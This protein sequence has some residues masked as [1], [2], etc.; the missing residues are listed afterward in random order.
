MIDEKRISENLKTFS[1]PRLSG[2][3]FEKKSYR[4]ARQ[5]IEDLN[6]T[7]TVQQFKFTT[8]YS[9]VYPKISLTL[10][11]WFALVLYLDISLIFTSINLITGFIVLLV[12]IAFTRSPEKIKK[13]KKLDS[14]NLFV[15]IPKISDENLTQSDAFPNNLDTSKNI[16][17]F[18]HLDSKGQL[19]P[20]KIRV[21]F[22]K[23]WI[24]S[25]LFC[26]FFI[27]INSFT[28]IN[29]NLLFTISGIFTLGINF[30]ATG[31]ISLNSTNNKSKGA[32]DDASGLSCV[33]ELLNY[34]SIPENRLRNFNLWFVFT[35]AEESGTMGIRNFYRYIQNLDR[36]N[37]YF[38]NFDSIANK[39]ILYD[40]GLVNNKNFKSYQ[41]ILENKDLFSLEGANKIYIGTYS[42]GIFLYNR[43]FQGLGIGD[44]SSYSYVHTIYD[45][46]DKINLTLLKKLCHFITLVLIDNDY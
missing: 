20:I 14:Q 9:R 12:F 11:F 7:P 3:Q 41:Y 18:A 33:M 40:N 28:S 36:R 23:T 15:K 21:I 13:G 24:I 29:S 38:I 39:A 25:Y 6:L 17:L 35:G 31:L 32:I 16:F 42:D 10:L 43:N 46:V 5:K 2:T 1:F 45:D 19:L 4:I 27:V 26:L 44:T 37:N 22:Y 34:Y 30:I 8:F